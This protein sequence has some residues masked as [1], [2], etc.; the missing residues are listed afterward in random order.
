[1]DCAFRLRE[2][3]K[4]CILKR[5]DDLNNGREIPK[6]VLTLIISSTQ[7]DETITLEALIDNFMT[8]YGAGQK[9]TAS[10]LTYSLIH[11]LH[12]PEVMKRLVEEV[13]SVFEEEEGDEITLIGLKNLTY[14]HAVLEEIL[15][16]YPPVSLIA[17]TPDRNMTLMGYHVPKGTLV[18]TFI[19]GSGRNPEMFDDPNTFNPSRFEPGQQRP[20]P[21]V[22]YPFGM[23]NRSCIGKGYA[24]MAAK[25]MLSHFLH[26]YEVKLS[27]E[28]FQLKRNWAVVLQP[29][30]PVYCTITP[31]AHT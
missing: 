29:P 19:L 6:D 15:R 22:Y 28:N 7:S 27:D 17:V 11:L 21:Y 13:D 4:H 25:V 10:M 30:D 9:T 1:M 16:M 18:T 12:E 24:M 26:K 31:R 14:M 8:F 5:I 23:G 2:I 3:G 20:S